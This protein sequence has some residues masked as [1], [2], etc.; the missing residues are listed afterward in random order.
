MVIIIVLWKKGLPVQEKVKY[1]IQKE[2]SRNSVNRE[3]Y[4]FNPKLEVME[5][6][7]KSLVI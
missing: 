7:L 2:L 6:S 5:K 3:H 4:N 1:F